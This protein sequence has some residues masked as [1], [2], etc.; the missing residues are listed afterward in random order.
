MTS[1]PAPT[2][3][4]TER[5]LNAVLSYLEEVDAGR[6]PDSRTML[7]RHPD[8]HDELAAFFADQDQVGSLL[9]PLRTPVPGAIPASEQTGAYGPGNDEE[10]DRSSG[11]AVPGYEMF[12]R[13]GVGGMGEVYKAFDPGLK[14]WVALKRVRLDQVSADRLAR[15]RLEAEALARLAHP[16]IVKVHGWKESDGQPVLEMEYVAGG[17]LEDRLGKGRLPPGDAARLVSILAWAVHA[18]HEKGIVH[19][20]LKLANVLLDAPVA[21]NPGTVLGGFPKVSD[22]GLAALTDAAGDRTLSGTVL[23]TPAYISPEQAAGK[24]LEIGPPT[25]VWALGVI[26]YRCLAGEL[27]FQGDNVLDTLE[28]VKTLQMRPL[29]ECCPDVPAGLEETCLACLRKVPAERPTAAALAARLEQLAGK[30]EKTE[31]MWARP[32]SQRRWWVAAGL[33]VASVLV[34]VGVWIALNTG[35]Q[36]DEPPLVNLRVQ[37]FE[38]DRGDD[39]PRGILGSE[40][41][42]ARYKDRVVIEVELSRPAHCFLL[43]CN[44]DGKWQLLWPCADQPP[45]QGDPGR[46]PPSVERLQYPP[47]PSQ[48]PHGKSW[49]EKGIALDDDKAGGMQGFVVVAARRPLPAYADW[50]APRGALPWQKLPP[51]QVVWWS[52]GQTQDRLLPGGH[53]IRGSV[54]DL[55]G[56]PP[57]L[58]LCAW[59]KGPDVDVVEGL[60]FPVYRRGD[61]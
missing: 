25:D 6:A 17:T 38:H 50:A 42:E 45:F 3:E 53:R 9:G 5:V 18:A 24:T 23:G 22:F 46:E 59:A 43:A 2:P 61:R 30:R 55:A 21:G 56:Q 35:S 4:R 19:R 60:M 12:T 16:H 13:L 32:R 33:L 20:D 52:D 49:K 10:G 34:A 47:P 28:R 48:G 40:S 14:R 7:D 41:F 27:P 39:V 57:L 58:Q 1:Q 15:F 26:L 44:F 36:I 37:H 51:A 29:R 54:V 8:L 31:P 11:S